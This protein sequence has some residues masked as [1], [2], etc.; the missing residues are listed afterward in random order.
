VTAPRL[1]EIGAGDPQPLEL[2]RLGEHPLEQLPVGGLERGSLGEGIARRR[3]PRRQSVANL[4]QLTQAD[5][6]RLSGRGWDRRIDREAGECLAREPGQLLL[7]P[8]DL[9]P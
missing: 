2:G 4:L 7:E 9:T 3:D 8:A 6:S 1:A 5:Q